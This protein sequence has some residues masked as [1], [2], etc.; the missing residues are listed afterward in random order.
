MPHLLG[1]ARVS[2]ATG[3]AASRRAP[4]VTRSRGIILRLVECAPLQREAALGSSMG[5]ALCGLTQRGEDRSDCRSGDV[6]RACQGVDASGGADVG[7]WS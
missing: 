2:I 1:Y 6:L 4:G 3:R 7:Q 5:E